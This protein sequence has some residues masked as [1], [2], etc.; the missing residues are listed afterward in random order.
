MERASRARL[1]AVEEL[2]EGLDE[3]CAS[4]GLGANSDSGADIDDTES[5]RRSGGTRSRYEAR[6]G[7]DPQPHL[8]GHM[9]PNGTSCP[10]WGLLTHIDTYGA[11]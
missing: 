5:G 10:T 2:A 3:L 6:G 9:D 7:P 1:R 11:S 8:W 4:L